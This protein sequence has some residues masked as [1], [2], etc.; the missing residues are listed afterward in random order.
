V[1]ATLAPELARLDHLL[2]REIL[3]LRAAYELS[4]DEFRG[5]YISDEQV[6]ALLLA[7]ARTAELLPSPPQPTPCPGTPWADL[8]ERLALTTL[9]QDLL[10]LGLAAEL[11]CKYATL[12][13]YLN[14][15]VARKWP[16]VDLAERLFGSA[17]GLR[18]AI[19][20]GSGLME[21]GL[22]EF[23]GR[24]GEQR[25]ETAREF[26]AS[27]AVARF[28]Q[29]L[30]WPLPA[31]ARLLAGAVG[32]QGP[33]R[34]LGALLAPGAMPRVL[35]EAE[36]G[37]GRRAA[38]L[39]LGAALDRPVLELE[40]GR[41]DEPWR[42]SLAALELPCRLTNALLL[43]TGI[44]E[45]VGDPAL[46]PA[47]AAAIGKLPGPVF[48]TVRPDLA[49]GALVAGGEVLRVA[50]PEPDA[51]LRRKFWAGALGLE[52]LAADGPTLDALAGRFRLTRGSIERAARAAALEHRL[53]GSGGEP[54]VELLFRAARD[55]SGDALQRLASRSAKRFG[56]ADLV[57][58]AATLTRLREV[59]AAIA[60]RDL[61]QSQWGMGRH[62]PAPDGLAVL[63]QGHS[64]TG[65]TLAASVIAGELGLELYRIDLS[66]VVSKYI[67]ETEKNLERIFAAARRSNAVLLFDEADALF[68]K[69]SEVKDAHD[70][71]ANLEV[72]Y[73]LQRMEQHDGPVI[74]ATN[75]AKNL[76]QAFARRLHYTIEFPRPDPAAR[77][78]LWRHMLAP[79][80]PCAADV[81][82][83]FLAERFELTGGEIRKTALEAAF[84]AAADG[85]IVTMRQLVTASAR[86]LQRQGRLVARSELGAHGELPAQVG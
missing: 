14:N 83:G 27:L 20:Q 42:S 25:P 52:G 63:F 10:L 22:L 76:D 4:L 19:T 59:M 45:S 8:I 61:V 79:P 51:A 49:A 64:G 21:R 82:T 24:D 43:L 70:R 54:P 65:K 74:L 12:F 2:H 50:W 17:P 86:E 34:R 16:T 62:S 11:D 72:A 47:L 32:D 33:L 48:L 78:R 28:V 39:A 66:S 56:W 3:R 53:A 81:D 57:L 30:P 67:G 5:L 84:A 29:G 23:V 36:W 75:L 69:R 40:L 68:G 38:L 26:A 41:N 71:Y 1:P 31:G 44:D 35:L 18:Q 15:D 80:L 73:L 13:A 60:N 6:D 46:R 77:D 9:E 37:S 58:P 55:Q 7:R 85:R